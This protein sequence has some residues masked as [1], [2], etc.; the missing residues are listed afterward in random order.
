MRA[1]KQ[2][3]YRSNFKAVEYSKRKKIRQYDIA[4]MDEQ[5]GQMKP[6]GVETP[7][8]VVYKIRQGDKRAVAEFSGDFEIIAG[9]ERRDVLQVLYVR[10]V[11]NDPE[12]VEHKLVVNG[13][14]VRKKCNQGY[15]DGQEDSGSFG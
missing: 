7:E 11:S 3:G 4:R 9:K 1:E 12:I 10:I 15:Q 8:R 6:R 14:Q 5:I 2:A 13:V